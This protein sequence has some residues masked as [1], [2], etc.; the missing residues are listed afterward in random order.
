MGRSLT[1]SARV[2]AGPQGF[3][4]HQRAPARTERLETD[5]RGRL[6]KDNSH[7][8]YRDGPVIFLPFFFFFNGL[9]ST[10]PFTESVNLIFGALI[11]PVGQR[12]RESDS[13]SPSIFACE[14]PTMVQDARTLDSVSELLCDLGSSVPLRT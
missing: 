13:E 5:T 8:Q 14:G 11:L 3:C 4:K 6:S 10:A 9:R 7:E 1:G 2:N 12:V